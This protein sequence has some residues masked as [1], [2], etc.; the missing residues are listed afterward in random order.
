ME[1]N[2]HQDVVWKELGSILG[3]YINILSKVKTNPIS[4]IVVPTRLPLNSQKPDFR[5][6]LVEGLKSVV[7]GDCTYHNYQKSNWYH[8]TWRYKMRISTNEGVDRTCYLYGNDI[9]RRLLFGDVPVEALTMVEEVLMMEL[10]N[11][12]LDTIESDDYIDR[13]SESLM[14]PLASKMITIDRLHRYT[15]NRIRFDLI[16]DDMRFHLIC[17]SRELKKGELFPEFTLFIE[18]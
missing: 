3:T 14:G 4:Y 5:K 15:D 17:S 10:Y 2:I 16:F 11:I 1:Y 7:E 12:P 9:D 13:L 18:D 6:N 8:F